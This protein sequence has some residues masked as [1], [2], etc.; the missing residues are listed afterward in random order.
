MN[1]DVLSRDVIH[2]DPEL[3]DRSAHAPAFWLREFGATQTNGG[4][5]SSVLPFPFTDRGAKLILDGNR[6]VIWASADATLLASGHSCISIANGEFGGRT[7]HSDAL[8]RDLCDD[9]EH[10]ADGIADLL[11]APEA[12]LCP[13][14]FVRAQSYSVPGDRLILLTIRNLARDLDGIPDL[15]RLY[16]LTRTEQQVTRMM[17]QGQSVTEIGS[18]L[19]KSVLTVRTHVKRVY[20]KLGV[21]TKEQLF[22]TVMKLM[23]D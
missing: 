22:S 8:V 15:G 13:E 14:L 4:S 5:H 3:Q 9:A 1:S 20:S 23:V 12:S 7:R 2:A 16:G 17:I 11:V 21:G 10:A 19:N 6:R 18:R